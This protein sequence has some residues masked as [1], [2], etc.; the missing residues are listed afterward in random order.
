M[1]FSGNASVTNTKCSSRFLYK[2]QSSFRF[3]GHS[4]LWLKDSFEFSACILE[5]RD[6]R[7]I[8][9]DT[10]LATILVCVNCHV[11]GFFMAALVSWWDHFFGAF[12]ISVKWF[13]IVKYDRYYMFI[14]GAIVNYLNEHVTTVHPNE[15]RLH[16]AATFHWVPDRKMPENRRPTLT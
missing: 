10:I 5:W 7:I 4:T 8:E 12:K 15:I 11:K 14:F 1:S 3:V 2:L 6:Q 9:S 13:L 16:L